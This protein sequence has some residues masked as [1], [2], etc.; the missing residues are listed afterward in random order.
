M[1]RLFATLNVLVLLSASTAAN[2]TFIGTA[3]FPTIPSNFPGGVTSV[4]NVP[5]S[6]PITGIAVVWS[7]ANTTRVGDLKI[8][9]L[10]P[11]GISAI[12]LKNIGDGVAGSFRD[13]ANLNGNYRFT[14]RAGLRSFSTL[15][16]G[17]TDISLVNAG[18]PS[19]NIWSE[20]GVVGAPAPL[21]D[22]T[23]DTNYILRPGDY[24]ASSNL[25]LGTTYGLNYVETNL[26]ATLGPS[27]SNGLW[28]LN[29]EDTGIGSATPASSWTLELL[30]EP[31]TLALL[32][33]GAAVLIRRR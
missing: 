18:T 10:A 16:G 2:A 30:P 4:I 20:A 31:A 21:G 11:S 25:L 26:L 27:S 23:H 9:L 32:A 1:K 14:D 8:S 6:F 22:T 29:I 3:S 5:D 15:G 19:G 24:I 13:N 12:L 28:L 33:L 7:G 17:A